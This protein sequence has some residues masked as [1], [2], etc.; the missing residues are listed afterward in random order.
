MDELFRAS[1]LFR[2]NNGREAEMGMW[3][4]TGFDL[5]GAISY[6]NSVASAAQALSNASLYAAK[7]EYSVEWEDT[8]AASISSDVYRKLIVSLRNENER[9]LVAIPSPA[10]MPL[11]VGGSLRGIRLQQSA[12]SVSGM[13][14]QIQGLFEGTLTP[15][16][17]PHPTIFV[18]AGISRGVL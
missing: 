1:F 6:M 4:P 12:S 14:A 11:D 8:P 9:R 15:W 7:L 2:D 17:T 3:L 5:S 10:E 16:G 13:Q 18:V